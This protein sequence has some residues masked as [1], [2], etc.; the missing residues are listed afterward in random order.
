ME[1]LPNRVILAY[2]ELD[3]LGRIIAGREPS[4]SVF[5]RVLGSPC[6]TRAA[7]AAVPQ[8]IFAKPLGR[9]D[10]IRGY[11][12]GI[13]VSTVIKALILLDPIVRVGAGRRRAKL[14]EY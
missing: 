14:R 10:R 4:A 2:C 7:L 5:D 12:H 11:T 13:G 8:F 1:F 9:A 6:R 3:Y